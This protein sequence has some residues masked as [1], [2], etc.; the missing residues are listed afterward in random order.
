MIT[1]F[2][3]EKIINNDKKYLTKQKRYAT[4]MTNGVECSCRVAYTPITN[5][6]GAKI[7]SVI[8]ADK[9]THFL[10]VGGKYGK[11]NNKY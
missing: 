10:G 8:Y 7:K 4:I 11:K 6:G 5:L 1:E 9:I 2:C 3:K